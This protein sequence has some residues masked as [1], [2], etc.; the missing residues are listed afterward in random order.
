MKQKQL[1]LFDMD[2]TL[3]DTEKGITHCIRLAMDKLGYAVPDQRILRK[4]IGPPLFD[5]FQTYFDM[6]ES[7]AA[8]ALEI[9]RGYYRQGGMYEVE[10]YPGIERLLQ[11][12]QSQGKKIAVATGKPE[13]FAKAILARWKLDGYFDTVVGASL[14]GTL[15]DKVDLI[16]LVHERLQLSDLNASVMIGDRLY[17]IEGAQAVG[18]DSIG[19]T[20]G[21]GSY[22]ELSDAG[23]TAICETVADVE[24]LLLDE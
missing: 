9:Y 2:G 1:I 22:D 6:D 18:I 20:Y 19:V 8:E 24:T 15:V 13:V 5:S 16:N 3:F 14:D 23:A 7:A 10:I 21:F 4:F 12:L 17:D 11:R